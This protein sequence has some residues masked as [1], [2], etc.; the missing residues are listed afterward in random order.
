MAFCWWNNA[1]RIRI[2]PGF[3][4]PPSPDT[5]PR[6]HIASTRSITMQPTVL[7]AVYVARS[8]R[9]ARPQE[10]PPSR[11]PSPPITQAQPSLSPPSKLQAYTS[12]YSEL[13]GRFAAAAADALERSG[14]WS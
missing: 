10:Q 13:D 8:H 9:P 1:E 6:S 4:S 14:A 5:L 11:A 12:T 7:A 2:R 3:T